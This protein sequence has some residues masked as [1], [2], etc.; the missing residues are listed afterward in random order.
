MVVRWPCR[1]VWSGPLPGG[2]GELTELREL[3]LNDNCIDGKGGGV[4]GPS[5]SSRGGEAGSFK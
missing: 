1:C 4:G 2:L 5:S 3:Y